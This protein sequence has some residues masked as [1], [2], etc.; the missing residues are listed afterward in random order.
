[1]SNLFLDTRYQRAA[2][3]FAGGLLG[4][5]LPILIESII[6]ENVAFVIFV[7]WILLV[8]TGIGCIL[9]ARYV[10]PLKV[11]VSLGMFTLLILSTVLIVNT[12]SIVLQQQRTATT[13][14][15]LPRFPNA[16]VVSHEYSFKREPFV[17]TP[18]VTMHFLSD[19][20]FEKIKRYYK[21]QLEKEGWTTSEWYSKISWR[22]GNYAI[23]IDEGDMDE[24]RKTKYWVRM[25]F[26]GSW[27]DD[28]LLHTHTFA[29]T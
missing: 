7:P 6:F 20:T 23:A 8:G 16:I 1:M 22:K 2:R 9:G 13:L 24:Q 12:K 29:Q 25:E 28:L 18:V 15:T 27:L 17:S 10:P 19:D 4:F 3:L 26:H 14:A 5:G 11:W 21:Q